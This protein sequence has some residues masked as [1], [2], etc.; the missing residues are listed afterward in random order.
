MFN[1]LIVDDE[2]LICKGLGSLLA[3]SGLSIGHVYTAYNAYEA[4]DNLRIEEIDLLITDIQMGDMNGIELI[5]QA[6]IIKP[7]V[8][9]II[10]SAHETFQYAQMALQLGA[11]DYL[12]KPFKNEQFL[13]SV[14]NVLLKIDKKVQNSD[15]FMSELQE[16]FH[17]QELDSERTAALNQLITA[18]PNAS[19]RESHAVRLREASLTGPYFA[20]IKCRL[21]YESKRRVIAVSDYPLFQYAALNIIDEL[22]SEECR[23]VVFYSSDQE[24]CMIVEW[25][26]SE[27]ENTSF[28][29][30]SQLEI[31]GRSIHFNIDQSIGLQA[32]V[33]IS[34]ILKGSEFLSVLTEQA[35]KAMQWNRKHQD[36]FVFYYGDYNWS[37]YS[38][39][40]TEE[41][42]QE[43]HNLIVDKAKDYI[44][45]NYMQKGLTLNEVAQRNHVSP[46]YLSYL[47]KKNTGYNLWEYVI[48]LR[49]EESRKLIMT[50]DMRRYEIADRVGY[51]SPE[52]FSKIFKKYY[53]ISPS[54]LKK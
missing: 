52:H 32:V 39:E 3:T 21:K 41:E 2:P 13:D 19:D 36:H 9:A 5:Q 46:N 16:N 18:A 49:M 50:T 11:K 30:M 43:Q 31:I 45:Q 34:Q 40:P 24:I 42:M 28:S 22:L 10:I 23:H 4:L 54:E 48:K 7:W 17:M 33:G 1:I 51:E 26:E 12:I 25:S 6:K 20:V 8:Q 14:R 35:R 47:F 38:H 44:N 53:G 37:L 27:Y 15:A 29:K